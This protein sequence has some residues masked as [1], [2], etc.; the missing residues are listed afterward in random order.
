[1]Y[2]VATYRLMAF[3]IVVHR[4][5]RA[6][7]NI[8]AY[9]IRAVRSVYYTARSNFSPFKSYLVL[10][11]LKYVACFR[12]MVIHANEDRNPIK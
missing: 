2:D 6:D 12:I 8:C 3:C 10:I 5:K 9:D 4:F 11:R 1:M 7:A